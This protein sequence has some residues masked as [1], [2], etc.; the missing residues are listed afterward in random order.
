MFPY[1]RTGLHAL[2]E[3]WGLKHSEIICPAYTCVVVAHA[4]VL[5]GNIPVFVDCE[6]GSFNMSVDGI[7]AALTAKTRAIIVTHLFGYPM[8][9]QKIADLVRAAEQRFQHKIY[10]IQD[11]AHS[12]GAKSKGELVT[13]WGD[14]AIFGLNI[15]KHINTIFGGMVTTT[16]EETCRQLRDYRK[17]QMT[18]GGIRRGLRLFLY[19]M[20]AG[21][22]FNKR[23]Y[24]LVHWLERKRFLDP[25]V[26]YYDECKIDF[27]KDWNQRPGEIEA[28][29]GEVQLR[30]YDAICRAKI[31]RALDYIREFQDQPGITMLPFVE[32]AT[33]S[34]CVAL[35]DN[36]EEWLAQYR[37]K[38]IQLGIIIEYAV[39]Y[40]PAYRQYCRGDYPVSKH[41]AEHTVNFPVCP[42]AVDLAADEK[43]AS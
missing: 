35:V 8:D 14:A 36:R 27:P 23:W 31:N 29:V 3:C 26:K 20:A 2:L 42:D 4:I 12:F 24:R 41:Y 5:S 22:A 18:D 16:S 15:S 34:H 11:A 30:K 13:R 32:G 21:L 1:G 10:V 19:F 9:V 33:Y 40:L 39:P 37:H 28:R 25:F 6:P 43:I 17:T 7:Q 38:G